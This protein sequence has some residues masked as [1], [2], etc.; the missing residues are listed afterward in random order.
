[1]NNSVVL[2]ER[3]GQHRNIH[4]TKACFDAVILVTKR[5]WRNFHKNGIV[6]A[7][8]Q[9]YPFQKSRVRCNCSL[10][11]KQ[12]CIGITKILQHSNPASQAFGC[13]GRQVYNGKHFC[14]DVPHDWLLVVSS[15][16]W[17]SVVEDHFC[18]S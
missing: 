1:L 11:P 16:T 5:V 6:T 8:L 17:E 12:H 18:R 14:P 4:K 3:N 10:T 2:Q 15:M 7:D 9:M 13:L